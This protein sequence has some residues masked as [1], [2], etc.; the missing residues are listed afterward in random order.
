MTH[1]ALLAGLIAFGLLVTALIARNG[2]LALLALP[3]LAYLAAGF[4]T[5]PDAGKLR[6]AASRSTVLTA[7]S[8]DTAIEVGVAVRN[9]G[10][11]TVL[12]RLSDPLPPGAALTAGASAQCVALA[13]GEETAL[14]YTLRTERGSFRWDSVGATASDLFGLF[15]CRVALPAPGE[16]RVQP[17]AR[18]TLR[19]PVRPHHTLNTPGTV[20]SRRAGSGT[21]FWGVRDYYPGDPL[22]HIDWRRSARHP[23]QLFT[24]EF[25]QE[26]TADIG[27]VLDARRQVEMVV[28]EDSLFEHMVAATASLARAFLHDGYRV[29]LLVYGT[30]VLTVFPGYSKGQLARILGAL[31]KARLGE[32]SSYQS[33]QLV[34]LS[35]LPSQA[36]IVVVSPL[37]LG[38]HAAFRRFQARS[39]QVLLLCPDT[40]RFARSHPALPQVAD[41]LAG[42]LAERAVRLE[43]RLELRRIAQL[44]VKVVDWP[45]DQPLSPLMRAALRGGPVRRVEA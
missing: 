41:D 7:E 37:V 12:V 17:R 34:P 28:G 15:E 18:R 6:L 3:P 44:R 21:D 45:V 42:R 14:Q 26:D 22:R 4:L 2:D 33:L 32:E 8:E 39:N 38:D 9:D 40:V 20:P 43:R 23:Q 11:D 19:L 36:L 25:E 35:L 16:I 29:S 13:P 5:A 30:P 10:R 31:A 27:L 24:R 1:R